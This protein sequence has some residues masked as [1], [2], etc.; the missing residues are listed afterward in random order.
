MQELKPRRAVWVVLELHQREAHQDEEDD[1]SLKV[2]PFH[3]EN[4]G[5]Q[6]DSLHEDHEFPIEERLSENGVFFCLQGNS[7][8]RE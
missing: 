1:D 3:V 7:V 6:H 2:G 8:T 4:C 5:H